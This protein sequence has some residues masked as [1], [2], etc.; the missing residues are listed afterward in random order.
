MILGKPMTGC[1]TV[2]GS[3]VM[4][5]I[6]LTTVN[7]KTI[8]LGKP[9]PFAQS[10]PVNAGLVDQGFT[11]DD[12][13]LV[14]QITT[15]ATMTALHELK[16]IIGVC[17]VLNDDGTDLGDTSSNGKKEAYAVLVGKD[18]GDEIEFQ[19]PKGILNR[20]YMG[21]Y[22]DALKSTGATAYVGV[23]KFGAGALKYYFKI[24]RNQWTQFGDKASN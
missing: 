21:L 24:G 4:A 2:K 23:V 22:V 12:F 20:N 16:F 7:A 15:A 17:D 9:V 10:D 6:S 13:R 11:K 3:T 19:I 14:I 1:S 8:I 18:I 5:P